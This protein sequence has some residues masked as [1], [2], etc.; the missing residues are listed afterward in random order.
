MINPID[1]GWIRIGDALHKQDRR[2]RRRRRREE[3]EEEEQQAVEEAPE[4]EEETK[5]DLV[6]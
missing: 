1:P 2:G 4:G 5:L 6:A 3:E